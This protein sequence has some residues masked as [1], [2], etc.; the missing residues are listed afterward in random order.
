MNYPFRLK[1]MIIDIEKTKPKNKSFFNLFIKNEKSQINT[2][3]DISIHNL[4]KNTFEKDKYFYYIYTNESI[5]SSK[6]NK[7]QLRIY[8]SSPYSPYIFNFKKYLHVLHFYQ[9][10][11]DDNEYFS[12]EELK[13][14]SLKIKYAISQYLGYEIPNPIMYIDIEHL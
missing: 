1:F 5:I 6:D 9:I 12:I 3:I 14:I 4:L 11:N 8:W 13:Y 10:L 2:L 7:N